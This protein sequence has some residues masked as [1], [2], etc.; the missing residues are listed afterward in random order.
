MARFACALLLALSLT[1]SGCRQSPL[2]Y[3]LNSGPD[4]GAVFADIASNSKP[5]SSGEFFTSQKGDDPELL[6]QPSVLMPLVS[7]VT[8]PEAP[9]R[10][11][12]LV[13]CIALAMENGRTGEFF[14]PAGGDRRSS[15]NGL[16]RQG[17]PSDNTDA[18]RVFAFDPAVL[19]TD[20]E[21]SLSRFDVIWDTGVFWNRVDKPSRLLNP[22][23]TAAEQFSN[24]NKLD[25]IGLRGGLLKPLSTGGFAGL[26]LSAD[27]EF[28]DSLPSDQFV[29]PTYRPMLAFLFEQP[30]LKGSGVAI[31]QV[32]DTHPN[33]VRNPVP[34]G[35]RVPGILLA[36][37]GHEQSKLEFERRIHELIFRVEDAYWSLYRAYWDLYSRENGM[38]QAHAAW[39]IAKA[40][41]DAGGIGIE[42]LAMVEEQFHFF[43]TQRLEALGRGTPSR[44]GVLEAERKLRYIIGLVAEDGMR[45]MPTDFPTLVPETGTWNEAWVDARLYRPELAQIQQEIQAGQLLLAKARDLLKPDLRFLAKYDINGLGREPGIAF[46]SITK[47]PRH[48]WELGLQMQMP[49][50]FRDGHSEV[51]RAYLQLAQRLA[52][53][54]DQEDKL[55]F[56]LQRSYRDLIQYREEFVTRQS[57]EKAAATQLKVR[58]DKY[59]AGGDPKLPSGAAIDLL[60]RAQRNWADA[61]RDEYQALSNYKT[62]LADFERQKGT[63]LRYHNVVVSDGPLPVYAVPSA[64]RHLRRWAQDQALYTQSQ[65]ANEDSLTL[66]IEP[67]VK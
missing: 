53:L 26:A 25:S 36:R 12:S 4:I 62:A 52:F 66:V 48:E 19:A 39:Q 65:P 15:V 60:L 31:N 2:L 45:L 34:T 40:R 17:T 55:V 44:P 22:N 13:E 42:D 11:I 33:S 24:R 47:N 61:L 49:I 10:P 32:R 21:Q 38:K 18:I 43:R 20:V 27:Y 56:S 35:N 8:M 58:Y 64:S 30:L 29:N 46:Q 51:Q 63:I 54:R 1:L 3:D 6:K 37:L 50:G 28:Q 59:M 57:Q 14:D 41:Y 9:K 7:S 5:L 67:A 23:P 16:T